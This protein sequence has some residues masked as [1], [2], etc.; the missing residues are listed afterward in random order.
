LIFFSF[1]FLFNSILSSKVIFVTED[2]VDSGL[3]ALTSSVF[4]SI[5][6]G[7]TYFSG[8]CLWHKHS[9]QSESGNIR[10]YSFALLGSIDDARDDEASIVEPDLVIFG[11]GEFINEFL[12]SI[13]NLVD[14][15]NENRITPFLNTSEW[16]YLFNVIYK[17]E[18]PENVQRALRGEEMD[19]G[20]W[21]WLTGSG[22]QTSETDEIESHNLKAY[23]RIGSL[24]SAIQNQ[25]TKIVEDYS[26]QLAQV[27]SRG[28]MSCFRSCCAV[29][30]DLVGEIG[31]AFVS[32]LA[33]GLTRES[34]IEEMDIE[35]TQL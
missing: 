33:Q 26:T 28:C 19:R 14:V 24:S 20:F 23:R 35:D 27:A 15:L 11:S 29:T 18:I 2:V 7:N 22:D 12:C 13:D 32:G 5:V 25:I 6:N 31:G 9:F 17:L 8:E 30:V 34:G 1:V 4:S 10:R 21:S 16:K 3:F